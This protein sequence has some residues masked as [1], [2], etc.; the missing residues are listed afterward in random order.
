MGMKKAPLIW[1]TGVFS[2]HVELLKLSPGQRFGEVLSL[3]EGLDLDAG[4]VLGGQRSLGL[5]HLAPELLHG[6][7]VLAHVLARLLLVEFDEVLHDAL[8]EVLSAQ[9]S[10]PVG[11]HHLEHAVVDGQQGHVEGAAAQVEHQDVLLAV[12]LIETVRDR[13]RRSVE[14][15]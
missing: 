13:S 1:Y 2:H 8:V 5:L 6:P 7:V 10:V 9:V 12:F 11:G 4:L 15:Q 3:E 14:I